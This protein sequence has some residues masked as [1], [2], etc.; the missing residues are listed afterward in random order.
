MCEWRREGVC[1]TGG[2]VGVCVCDWRGS[3]GSSNY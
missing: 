2:R 1:V 3:G